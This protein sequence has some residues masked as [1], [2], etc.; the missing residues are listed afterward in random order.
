[1]T[2]YLGNSGRVELIRSGVADGLLSVVNPSDIAATSNRFSFEFPE[3]SLIT[4]DFVKIQT[5]D[6]TN[7]DFIAASGWS[8]GSV[9]PDGNWYVNVDFIGGIML[10]PTFDQSIAG[11]AAGRVDL[12]TIARNIPITASVINDTLRPVGQITSYE[13]TTDR[14]TVDTSSLGDEFRNQYSTLITGSG[15]LTCLFDYRYQSSSNY[16]TGFPELSLYLHTLLLRQR[17]GSG[18]KARLYI[19]G[20]GYGQENNDEIWHEIDGIIT[21][22]GINCNSDT[23]MIS[24][25]SFVTTGEIKLRIQVADPEYLLQEDAFRVR[26]EDNTGSVLLEG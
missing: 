4:G 7:L 9:F 26:L 10:Y 1:M 8:A 14:E 16:P 17:F 21:Q 19:L 22:A 20:Q 25:I 18:F 3:G 11:E 23:A 13:F 6:G 2:V 15:Q 5:T 24:T 12:V